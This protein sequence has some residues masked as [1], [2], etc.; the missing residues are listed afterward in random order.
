MDDVSPSA[1]SIY[2][3]KFAKL[4]MLKD[5]PNENNQ[6]ARQNNKGS[7]FKRHQQDGTEVRNL[8]K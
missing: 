8:K 7:T 4:D 1:Q 2:C 5:L 3:L 6:N